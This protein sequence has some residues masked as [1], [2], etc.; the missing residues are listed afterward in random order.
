[1]AGTAKGNARTI[2]ITGASSGIGHHLAQALKARGWQ[3]LASCRKPADCARLEA[4]G[5]ASP[6]IDYEDPESIETGFAEALGRT[7]GRLDALFNNGAYALPGALEDVPVAGLRQI[8]EANFFGWHELTRRAIPVMRAQG[9]GR[10][11][12][13]SSVLGFGY[14]RIRGAYTAT[15]HALEGYTDTLRLELGGTPIRVILLEP[16]PIRTKFRLNARAHYERWIDRENSA[17]ADFYRDVVDPRL[18]GEASKP[19]PFELGPEATTRKLIHALESRRPRPRYYVTT[20]TY[21]VGMLKRLLPT[22]LLDRI[23][24]QG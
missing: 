4:E 12:M 17:W 10:I 1:M 15:K 20:P 13:N 16:G 22:G 19:D 24:M 11:V 23:F 9:H 7:G 3:V 5:L 14:V 6:R 2:L 21:I 18:F 8:F